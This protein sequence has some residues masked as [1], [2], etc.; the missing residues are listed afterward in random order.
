MTDALQ[1]ML[2]ATSSLLLLAVGACDKS[3][4]DRASEARTPKSKESAPAKPG[5]DESDESGG[6]EDQSPPKSLDDLPKGVNVVQYE[7]RRLNEAMHIILTLI[8]NDNL[9][10]IPAQIKTKVHPA[11]QLTEKALKK[12][13][14]SPPRNADQMGAFAEQDAK[15][16]KTLKGLFKAAKADD[17]QK[18]TEQY[19][20]LVHGCSDCHTKFRFR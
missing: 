16:H 17:L 4:S 5:A 20:K 1:P 6:A 7:M 13:A 18:A 11:R 10:A 15:F 19:G 3:S 8:A 12:G 9:Q 14:Y 2:I